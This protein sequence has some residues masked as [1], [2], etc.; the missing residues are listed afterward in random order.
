MNTMAEVLQDEIATGD[1]SLESALVAAGWEVIG[2]TTWRLPTQ[3]GDSLLTEI[4]HR[5]HWRQFELSEGATPK[6]SSDGVFDD[7]YCLSGPAKLIA[8]KDDCSMCRLDMPDDLA[9]STGNSFAFG[10]YQHGFDAH[11]AWIEA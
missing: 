1:G 5:D 2:P 6:S 8:R 10:D 9:D 4:A 3:K 7:N 11:A